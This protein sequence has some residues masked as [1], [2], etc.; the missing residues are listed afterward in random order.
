MTEKGRLIRYR[1]ELRI[2]R[3][4]M[5]N[6]KPMSPYNWEI[7]YSQGVIQVLHTSDLSYPYRWH[8]HD[9]YEI[10][11]PIAAGGRAL[12]GD[13]NGSYQAGD[14]YCIGPRLPHSFYS[15]DAGAARVAQRQ[16]C[17]L[18]YI[19][20][21]FLDGLIA[22]TP[23]LVSL[24]SLLSQ[25]QRGLRFDASL[26]RQLRYQCDQALAGSGPERFIALCEVL[27]MLASRTRPERLCSQPIRAQL[28]RDQAARIDN[29][30]AY[31]HN[32][33]ASQIRLPEIAD[34]VAMHPDALG[35]L[36]KRATGA[37]ITDHLADIRVHAAC[38]LLKETDLS[39]TDIAARCGF[40]SLSQC[41]RVFKERCSVSPRQWRSQN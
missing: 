30:C 33:Y 34:H 32:N 17:Y 24:Q 38:Q 15:F 27:H 5:L 22:A 31:L 41:N 40:G 7:D 26:G 4:S 28:D 37:C 21:A 20:R 35:R 36:F 39:I 29:I 11:H 16:E 25:F 8:F 1:L 6:M 18:L 12:V 10:F 2:F 23:E 9:G 14:I 13:W 19:N 3:P